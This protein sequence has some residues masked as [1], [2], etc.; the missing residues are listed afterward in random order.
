MIN[1]DLLDKNRIYLGLQYG[2]SKIAK[3]IKR[4]SK[5]Y[6]PNSKHIPTHVCAF[7]YRKDLGVWYV[8][9]SHLKGCGKHGVPSGVRRYSLEKWLQIEAK[10][11]KEFKAI[12]LDFNFIELEDIVGHR[13]GKGDIMS[14]MLA[15][16]KRNNG[17][18]KDRK[19]FICSEYLAIAYPAICK[20]FDNLPPWC[21]TPAHFQNYIESKG[22][23][24]E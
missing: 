4:F 6:A 24:D 23:C 20:F 18:Q 1:F 5:R 10:A 17:A 22:L 2:N 13:Y 12:P 11:L 7:V 9:E 8:Y 3:E 19:G 16:I 21:V 15:A 14:L